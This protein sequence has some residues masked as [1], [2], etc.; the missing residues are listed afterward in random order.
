MPCATQAEDE[1]LSQ[2]WERQ[3]VGKGSRSSGAFTHM[4]TV[5]Y[6][7]K[8]AT[9]ASGTLICPTRWRTGSGGSD[10]CRQRRVGEAVAGRRCVYRMF[11]RATGGKDKIPG[12]AV[13]HSRK[14]LPGE[15]EPE[16]GLAE[17]KCGPA[18]ISPPA[19][20]QVPEGVLSRAS[21]PLPCPFSH[22]HTT[23]SGPCHPLLCAPS[24]HSAF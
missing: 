6:D 9:W 22:D 21:P 14:A 10:A 18:E 8:S 20:V 5:P 23:S 24:L 12:R 4:E 16:H 11:A 7:H 1:A 19:F 3:R 17:W 15:V 2:V 13:V